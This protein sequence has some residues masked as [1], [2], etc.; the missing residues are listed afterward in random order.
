MGLSHGVADCVSG[1]LIGFLPLYCDNARVGMLIL[2]FNV[3]AFAGQLPAGLLIDKLKDPRIGVLGSLGLMG[4]GLISYQFSPEIGILLIGTGSG[5]FHVAGGRVAIMATEGQ[6]KGPGIFAAPGV[7]GLA[8]GGFLA[9]QGI[10]AEYYLLA[11]LGVLALVAAFLPLKA[12]A[13]LRTEKEE[14]HFDMHDLFML[15]LLIAIAMRSAIWNLYQYIHA[16]QWELLL[17]AGAAAAVG[18]VSGGFL[19][20]WLGWK[21]YALIA[22]ISS[23]TL[24]TLGG[25]KPWLFIPGI[26][27]LQSATPLAVS[28]MHRFMPHKPATTAGLTFGLAIAIGGI[29]MFMGLSPG[30]GSNWIAGGVLLAAAGLYFWILHRQ[31]RGVAPVK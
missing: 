19:A 27:L 20:D 23:A 11:G 14:V 13:P 18:K 8:I 31:E 17:L 24:L 1:M 4:A 10:H 5:F 3:L 26:A 9:I 25:T 22:L 16:E 2:L 29:P 21:R 6:A 30:S 28:A 12:I 7:I 15:I